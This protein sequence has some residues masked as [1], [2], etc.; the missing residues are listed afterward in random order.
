MS[1]S[2]AA[3]RDSGSARARWSGY[4]DLGPAYGGEPPRAGGVLRCVLWAALLSA[5]ALA[6]CLAFEAA[7]MFRFYPDTHIN[8]TDV[9]GMTALEASDAV[10]AA[11]MH[12]V[13]IRFR[14]CEAVIPAGDLGLKLSFEPSV[15]SLASG[16]SGMPWGR[17]EYECEASA[18][19]DKAVVLAAV[20]AML[21]ANP[22]VGARTDPGLAFTADGR[23]SYHDGAA[24]YARD[25][26]AARDL[27]AE[28]IMAGAWEIDV[29]GMDCY[30]VPYTVIPDPG[31]SALA[32]AWNLR[33]DP[34]LVFLT[35]SG[36]RWFEA[37]DLMAH[38]IRSGSSILLDGP[39][40]R[41]TVSGWAGLEPASGLSAR[42]VPVSAEA[43][44]CILEARNRSLSEAVMRA[45]E[46]GRTRVD[47]DCSDMASW[48]S[49]GYVLSLDPDA[50]WAVLY[51][52]GEAVASCAASFNDPSA[53]L[54]D[55]A[56]AVPGDGDIVLSTGHSVG[57]PGCSVELSDPA[58]ILD[59]LSGNVLR[60]AVIVGQGAG[61]A[62]SHSLP[63]GQARYALDL[64]GQ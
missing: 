64:V 43:M 45:F 15:G 23:L 59:A 6:A 28:L 46:D 58:A 25:D 55:A 48:L 1:G 16:Q 39:W 21:E 61:P 51:Y 38:A 5:A 37:E 20:N 41:E 3:V 2:E 12:D 7:Y 22:D 47:L 50:E 14:S 44:A 31:L 42:G 34:G 60:C 9:S 30:D 4:G 8:G 56:A 49:A 13:A 26:A 27:I 11:A 62:E 53:V 24:G 54:R 29:S 18:H 36:E 33:A 52:G 19:Y 17:H 63:E 40:V 10:E 32:D 35:G 57:G